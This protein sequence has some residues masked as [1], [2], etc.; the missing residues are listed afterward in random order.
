M[1]ALPGTVWR[2]LTDPASFYPWS[3]LWRAAD[4]SDHVRAIVACARG[5]SERLGWLVTADQPAG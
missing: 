4:D 2:P 1:P 5:M 3:I